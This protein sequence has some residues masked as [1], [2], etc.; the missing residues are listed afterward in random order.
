MAGKPL[1]QRIKGLF[2]GEPAGVSPPAGD[3]RGAGAVG[4]QAPRPDLADKAPTWVEADANPFGVRVLDV[5]PITLGTLSLSRDPVCATNA[6]SYGGE[7]GGSFIAQPPRSARRVAATL[8]YR[9]PRHLADGALFIPQEME[10]KWALFLHSGTLLLV[11][12]WL[13]QVFLRAPVRLE[14]GDGDDGAHVV[15]GPLEG[16]VMSDE[17]P[18]AFTVAAVDFI[19]RSHALRVPW[20]APLPSA[21]GSERQLAQLC[22][23]LYGRQAQCASVAP[24]PA[25]V[26]E[27]PLCTVTRLHL[28]ALRDDVGA[29]RAALDAG[30]PVDL[31]DRFGFTAMHYAKADGALLDLL[32]ERGARVDQPTFEGATPLM[33]AT[34]SRD[35]ALVRALLRRGA[36]ADLVDQR[37]FSALHR[38]AEMGEVA[39]V[40]ALLAAGAAPDREAQ[41][42]ITPRKLAALRDEQ[43]VL[44]LFSRGA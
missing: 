4:I 25:D 21:E 22:M 1:W 6:V 26:P 41:G 16:S 15:I 29:A 19:V 9:A 38:A 23:S 44:A 2:T 28:A 27:R 18:E 36:Q 24:P 5:R 17:E 30:L 31:E 40:E 37:G 10:D 12:G 34:Q 11:R 32:L 3:V 39:I 20:P 35:L 7:D 42:G 8:R 13:R 43:A 33:T 14:R